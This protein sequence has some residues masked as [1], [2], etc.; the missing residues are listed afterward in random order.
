MIDSHYQK[1]FLIYVMTIIEREQKC[2]QKITIQLTWNGG[3]LEK[4]FITSTAFVFTDG[5]QKFWIKGG[6]GLC[7]S[8]CLTHI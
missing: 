8:P 2:Y 4:S 1:Q 3:N 6:W 7:F 5:Q